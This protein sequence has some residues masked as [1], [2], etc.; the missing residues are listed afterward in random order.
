MP[1]LAICRLR[2]SRSNSLMLEMKQFC[3]PLIRDLAE[4]LLDEELL[5]EELLAEELLAKDR[6]VEEL[7]DGKRF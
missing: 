2:T 6:L 7:L 3:F 4:E 5:D 1:H